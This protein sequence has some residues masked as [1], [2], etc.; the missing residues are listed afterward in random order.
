LESFFEATLYNKDINQFLANGALNAIGLI[1]EYE[2]LSCP[3][4]PNDVQLSVC[5]AHQNKQSGR[6]ASG[7]I[8][9]AVPANKELGDVLEKSHKIQ[10]RLSRYSHRMAIYC[11]VQLRNYRKPMLNPDPANETRWNGTIDETV[12]ANMIMGDVSE[13]LEIFLSAGVMIMECLP[14]LAWIN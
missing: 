3:T 5:F 2:S 11:E 7:T 1:T 13:M 14:T 12:R 10:A 4:R 8:T 6:Y 9:F